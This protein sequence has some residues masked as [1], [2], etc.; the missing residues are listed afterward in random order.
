V[1]PIDALAEALAQSWTGKDLRWIQTHI[2]HVFLAEDC[3][4]KLRKAVA[5]PFLDFSTRAARNA[6]CLL[7]V[8]LNRRLAPDVYL[9]VAPVLSE[10]GAAPS[11]LSRR[12]PRALRAARG[13]GARA[14]P[15]HRHVRDRLGAAA[16]GVAVRPVGA[17]REEQTRP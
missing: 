1:T 3:V 13:V 10:R 8:A 14:P 17:C 2:N 5:L 12:E 16:R 11:G 7:E 4:F 15:R 6:D 9:G